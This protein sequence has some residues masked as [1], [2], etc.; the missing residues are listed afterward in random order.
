M[1]EEKKIII[2]VE[3]LKGYEIYKKIKKEQYPHDK[4]IWA[5]LSGHILKRIE[6]NGD[7]CIHLENLINKKEVEIIDYHSKKASLQ[8]INLL[9]KNFLTNEKL[10]ISNATRQN[11]SSVVFVTFY[12]SYILSKIKDSNSYSKIIC[13]GKKELLLDNDLYLNYS[14]F[15]T[16]F[17]LIFSQ[18]EDYSEFVID[19]KISLEEIN[20][21]IEKKKN[22]TI[23]L[24]EKI[25][26]LLEKNINEIIFKIFQKLNIEKIYN[27]F[28]ASNKKKPIIIYGEN[29]I[30][31]NIFYSILKNRNKIY[32]KKRLNFKLSQIKYEQDSK[33]KIFDEVIKKI[34]KELTENISPIKN[35]LP[36]FFEPSLKL[37]LKKYF[38]TFNLIDKN[39]IELEK[40]FE[41]NSKNFS[42]SIVLTNGFYSI[43]EKMFYQ[44]YKKK[45]DN[46][47]IFFSH[48]VTIG[49]NKKSLDNLG[50]S[51]INFSDELVLFDYVS[52]YFLRKLKTNKKMYVSGMPQKNLFFKKFFKFLIKQKLKIRNKKIIILVV[53]SEK[54]NLNHSSKIENDKVF[55]ENI[56][57]RVKY[58]KNNYP[59][60][61]ILLK[62][63]PNQCFYDEYDF[64]ELKK[65][66][67]N[68]LILKYFEFRWLSY[69]ADIIFSSTYE[70]TP[71]YII[72]SGC[73]YY[74]FEDTNIDITNFIK[75]SISKEFY[76]F[77]KKWLITEFDKDLFKKLV[78]IQ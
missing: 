74:Q 25:I 54:N 24:T 12:K 2:I 14:H 68:L 78:K 63:Y 17:S 4:F 69:I 19:D 73:E 77:K 33:D 21:R 13:V 26:S 3:S 42:N 31:S 49:I 51:M 53:E 23:S 65:D 45:F 55:Y 66:N 7:D 67:D 16:I 59:N 10:S 56:K 8:I 38:F 48:G 20:Q 76:I 72:K 30:I 62:L 52:Y 1:V 9:N 22:H 61:L 39:R 32:F 5:S 57:K 40:K 29:D 11:F 41:N 28:V 35:L 75:I 44:F 43:P 15:D 50:E 18:S 27:K 37:I 60:H 6:E 46:K 36:N 34:N 71:Q 58:L 47:T 70:S 64:D